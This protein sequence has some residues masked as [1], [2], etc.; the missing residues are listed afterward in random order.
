MAYNEIDLTKKRLRTF[1]WIGV[2]GLV[3]S[4]LAPER[5]KAVDSPIQTKNGQSRRRESGGEI[6]EDGSLHVT[7]ASR[8][9]KFF[10][11]VG[12]STPTTPSVGHA[13]IFLSS[14][15]KQA[16]IEF[17]DGTVTYLGAGAPG[18]ITAVNAGLGLVG[19]GIAGPVTLSLSTPITSSYIPDYISG[20]SV[21][22][23]YIH[24]QSVLQTGAIAHISSATA[25]SGFN[26]GNGTAANPAYG[27]NTSSGTGFYKSN[28]TI[29]VVNGGRI[30]MQFSADNRVGIG[31]WPDPV[32]L[33]EMLHVQ[34][35]S[36]PQ[37]GGAG[38][39]DIISQNWGTTSSRFLAQ[40]NTSFTV[41]PNLNLIAYL[42]ATG[43]ADSGSWWSGGPLVASTNFTD[44]Q[45][46]LLSMH[47]Y[48]GTADGYNT[49]TYFWQD[50]TTGTFHFNTGTNGREVLRITGSSTTVFE[51]L[52][53]SSPVYSGGTAGTGNQVLTSSG[54]SGAPYWAALASSSMLI[55]QIVSSATVK[56]AN[57]TS[58]SYADSN[59]TASITPSSTSSKIF[60]CV[61]QFFEHGGAGDQVG[62]QLLR[63]A[64][65]INGPFTV[66]YDATATQIDYTAEMIYLDSPAS[67][68][69]L[70]YKT[71]FARIAGA[72]TVTA[73]PSLAPP[74][75]S[76]IMLFELL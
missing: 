67:V 50:N 43:T 72:T 47:R 21:A 17:D 33:A 13:K 59:L 46:G 27:F 74:S 5:V 51:N 26:T 49:D 60:V 19:G 76:I 52:V 68:S 62:W 38:S 29:A 65:I 11:F 71:Q 22:A 41:A 15:A 32:N 69:A 39:C 8:T 57:S 55:K 56:G 1:F 20:S 44:F 6:I 36:T 53:I 16:G 18:D 34:C 23:T 10:E 30:T 66:H 58:A 25:D 3:L 54:T 35:T 9:D 24:N 42:G 73:Q 2:G 75:Q 12:Q 48:F 45:N 28:S 64:S 31:G 70:A 37:P 61:I 40:S 63:G 4:I 14:A 7:G